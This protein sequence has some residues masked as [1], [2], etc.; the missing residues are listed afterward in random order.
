MTNKFGNTILSQVRLT[1]EEVRR[2]TGLPPPPPKPTQE[3][4]S[5]AT[6]LRYLDAED[7]RRAAIRLR[8]SYELMPAFRVMGYPAWVIAELY[9][10]S[11]ECVWKRLKLAGMTPRKVGPP[12]ATML[13]YL[14]V[15]Y[16]RAVTLLPPAATQS[17]SPAPRKVPLRR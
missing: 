4:V 3:A 1:A 2:I 12:F 16:T 5:E 17:C 15:R 7:Q 11:D 14:P 13:A 10:V 6:A 9:C 8:G